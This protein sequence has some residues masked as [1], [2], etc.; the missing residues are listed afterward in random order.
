MYRK[1]LENF[2]STDL[3]LRTLNKN[4]LPNHDGYKLLNRSKL[5]LLGRGNLSGIVCAEQKKS[6]L[7]REGHEWL[8]VAAGVLVYSLNSSRLFK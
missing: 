1:F 6:A 3:H 4:L 5:P 2:F 8:N 7:A